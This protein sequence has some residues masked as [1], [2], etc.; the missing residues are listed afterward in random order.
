MKGKLSFVVVLIVLYILSTGVSY[1]IF[2]TLGKTEQTIVTPPDEVD[3][4]DGLKIDTSA[5]RTEACP[6]NG[7][8]HTAQEKAVWEKRRPLAVMLENHTE[9]RPHSGLSK[10]DIVYETV[11]EGGITRFMGIFYCGIA[12]NTEFAPVRSART[13]FLDWVSEYDALYNH[14]GGAGI[15]SDTTVDE[16]AKALCQ[17]GKYKIKDLDQFGISFPTCFRNPDRLGRPVATEHQMVCQSDGLY[18]I[19]EQR[20]WTDVDSTGASWTKA[21]TPWKFKEEAKDTERGTVAKVDMFWWKGY[22]QY[23]ATWEYDKAANEYKRLTGGQ[24]HFDQEANAQLSAK[25]IVVQFVKETGPVDGHKHML[26]GTIGTGDAIIFMDGNSTEGTWSKKTRTSRTV[27][28]DG[29]GKEIIFNP[30]LI[31]IEAI[32]TGNTVT[33]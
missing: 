23:E 20:G 12:E 6:L 14:V 11:A 16:R 25:N 3:P 27:F 13:Y 5:P 4:G 1:G 33:Y 9:A 19:A 18:K 17:I 28:K 30:G 29:K 22:A 31:W 8:L 2:R 32:P 10:A 7:K 24:P 15:C 21:F 26:Y